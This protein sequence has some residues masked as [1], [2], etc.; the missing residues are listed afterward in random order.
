[1]GLRGFFDALTKIATLPEK[2][3]GELVRQR[4]RKRG[5]PV[6]PMAKALPFLPAHRDDDPEERSALDAAAECLW[7]D[8][9]EAVPHSELD[10]AR[11]RLA[12]RRLR[13]AFTKLE[14]AEC[15]NETPKQLTWLET[16]YLQTLSAYEATKPNER[17]SSLP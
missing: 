1:M 9:Q 3:F 15:R 5:L 2:D 12:E 16:L 8:K 10:A 11:V 6:A 7:Q 14:A 4:R 17:R 13:E